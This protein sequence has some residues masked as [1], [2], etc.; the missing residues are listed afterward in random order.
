M[1][2]SQLLRETFNDHIHATFIANKR[3]EIGEYNAHVSGEFEK[4][5]SD[6]EVQKYLP[7]L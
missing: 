6:Y 5:V 3:A 7:F 2:K 4:Q 1:E